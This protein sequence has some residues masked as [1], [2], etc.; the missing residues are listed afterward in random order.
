MSVLY[1]GMK[2][3]IYSLHITYHLTYKH[4]N[5]MIAAYNTSLAVK[6]KFTLSETGVT[7]NICPI[8][9]YVL[10]ALMN[11]AHYTELSNTA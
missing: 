1:F 2:F 5:M 4:F 8:L 7:F 9:I 6:I 10:K 11:S 3:H